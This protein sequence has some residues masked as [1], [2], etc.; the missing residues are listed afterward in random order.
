VP[1]TLDTWFKEEWL[2]TAGWVQAPDKTWGYPNSTCRSLHTEA[3][4]QL[5]QILVELDAS[6]ELP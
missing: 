5:G 4:Y 3:A 2:R 6:E 1:E